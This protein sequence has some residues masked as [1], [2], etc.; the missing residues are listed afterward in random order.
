MPIHVPHLLKSNSPIKAQGGAVR[1][2]EGIA[3]CTQRGENPKLGSNR[4]GMARWSRI[5]LMRPRPLRRG[6]EEGLLKLPSE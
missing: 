3:F 6:A 4:E 1:E 2:L 5:R